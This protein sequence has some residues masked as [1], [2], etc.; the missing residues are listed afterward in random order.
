MGISRGQMGNKSACG[1]TDL[2]VGDSTEEQKQMG[3][4]AGDLV[5][6]ARAAGRRTKRKTLGS[7]AAPT[8]PA[9]QLRH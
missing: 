7:E 5:A 6:R 2:R 9:R 3:V 4:L 1:V 8:L